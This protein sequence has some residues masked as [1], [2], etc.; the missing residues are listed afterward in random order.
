M[1]RRKIDWYGPRLRELRQQA[2]LSQVE[3]G[4][5]IDLAGSQI[6]KLE[7]NVNQPTLATALAIADALG[8]PFAAF[9]PPPTSLQAI[10]LSPESRPRGRRPEQA[11]ATE[12]AATNKPSGR[13]SAE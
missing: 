5:R 6:N 13:N 10:H 1:P 12:K 4:S 8:V 9:L 7:T 3:L 2:G 11:G